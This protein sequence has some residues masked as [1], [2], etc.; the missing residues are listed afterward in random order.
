VWG[1]FKLREERCNELDPETFF[2]INSP[3]KKVS[4]KDFHDEQGCGPTRVLGS[5]FKNHGG[6]GKM[7]CKAKEGQTD[8]FRQ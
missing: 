4:E 1:F 6:T 5:R 3:R 2:A 7:V 8:S